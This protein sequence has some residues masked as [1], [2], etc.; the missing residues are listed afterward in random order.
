MQFSLN[1]VQ[2]LGNV[3]DDIELKSTQS[4]HSVCN[5]TI[6][7]NRSIKKDDKFEDVASF[8]RVKAWA[9]VAEFAAKNLKKGDKVYADGRLDYH[10]YE[11]RDGKKVYVT[12]IV[13]DNIIPMSKKNSQTASQEEA[14]PE[15]GEEGK[16]NVDPDDIPF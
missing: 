8:H 4:G 12:D 11:D 16:E 5:F 6:A 1:K 15:P 14:E 13:L 3:A 10:S 7:T 2:L 9:T